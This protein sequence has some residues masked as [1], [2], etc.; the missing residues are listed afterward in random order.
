M[1]LALK[2]ST[3]VDW[4]CNT[5]HTLCVEGLVLLKRCFLPYLHLNNSQAKPAAHFLTSVRRWAQYPSLFSHVL[6][7]SSF[8]L[9]MWPVLTFVTHENQILP[10]FFKQYWLYMKIMNFWRQCIKENVLRQ[11]SSLK[12]IYFCYQ[13]HCYTKLWF[14]LDSACL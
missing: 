3:N 2:Q 11:I 14:V 8:T 13:E 7:Q 9:G 4:N 5:L 6:P 12:E 1:A 10:E